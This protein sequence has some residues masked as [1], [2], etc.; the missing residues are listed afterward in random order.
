MTFQTMTFSFIS[1]DAWCCPA[2]SCRSRLQGL[3]SCWLHGPDTGAS[4]FCMF[5]SLFLQVMRLLNPNAGW[6]SL[7]KVLF[8]QQCRVL[9]SHF[10]WHLWA[11][12]RPATT[13][14]KRALN[15]RLTA[16]ETDPQQPKQLLGSTVS[17]ISF[18]YQGEETICCCLSQQ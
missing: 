17:C 3:A 12:L 7:G 9:T 11:S 16:A 18:S 5:P 4:N 10:L 8:E 13:S 6:N 14:R 15:A 1:E 2:R